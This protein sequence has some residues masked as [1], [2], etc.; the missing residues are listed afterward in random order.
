MRGQRAWPPSSQEVQ[1][2]TRSG[3]T[4]TGWSPSKNQQLVWQGK[5]RG[6]INEFMK[7]RDE[8]IALFVR[9]IVENYPPAVE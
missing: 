6:G 3:L 5:G 2:D 8:R 7:N 4:Q 9:E 1:R